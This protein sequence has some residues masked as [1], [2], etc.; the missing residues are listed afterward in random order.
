MHLNFNGLLELVVVMQVDE[1]KNCSTPLGHSGHI[2]QLST[3]SHS[4]PL[5]SVGKRELNPDH[6]SEYNGPKVVISLPESLIRVL[7]CH[8]FSLKQHQTA[9]STPSDQSCSLHISPFP[10][11]LSLSLNNGQSHINT[12]GFFHCVHSPRWPHYPRVFCLFVPW[13]KKLN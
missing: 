7:S 13:L 6:C 10:P 8:L 5:H 11:F 3:Y 9:Q 12:Q 4:S 2:T 1:G